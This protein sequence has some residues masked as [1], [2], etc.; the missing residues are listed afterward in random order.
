MEMFFFSFWPPF[1]NCISDFR[2]FCCILVLLDYFI[3][4]QS[5]SSHLERRAAQW[6]DALVVLVC[7]LSESSSRWTIYQWPAFHRQIHL[8]KYFSELGSIGTPPTTNGSTL[9]LDPLSVK[10]ICHC[11]PSERFTIVPWQYAYK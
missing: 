7:G 2:Y 5:R 9:Y 6:R 11:E 8:G 10:M 3:S 4:S 1:C